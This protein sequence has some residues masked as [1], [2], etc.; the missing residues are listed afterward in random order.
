MSST[1]AG[2][3]PDSDEEDD[4]QTENVSMAISGPATASAFA[5]RKKDPSIEEIG[6]P[7]NLGNFLPDSGATHIWESRWLMA[8]SSNAPLQAKY[9]CK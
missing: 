5:V 8:T 6:D 4:P 7:C 2:D 3:L 1:W 9:A